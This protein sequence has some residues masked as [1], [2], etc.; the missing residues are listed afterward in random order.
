M[1]I[2]ESS[3]LMASGWLLLGGWGLA[4]NETSRAEYKNKY[5]S[6]I[7]G[8]IQQDEYFSNGA[9]L[10]MVN[11]FEYLGVYPILETS[12]CFLPKFHW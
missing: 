7:V 5:G 1:L 8:A 3:C 12:P 9:T 11:E 10:S 2:G 4:A 6:T